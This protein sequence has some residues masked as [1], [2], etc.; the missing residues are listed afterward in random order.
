[1]KRLL[2]TSFILVFLAIWAKADALPTPVLYSPDD[3]AG[4]VPCPVHFDWGDVDGAEAYRIQVATSANG[5]NSKDGFQSQYV[6]KETRINDSFFLWSEMKSGRDYYWSVRAGNS[7]DGSYYAPYRR[8][9]GTFSN[10]CPP[11]L[12]SPANNAANVQEP[13]AFEWEDVESAEAY[14]I[15]VATS[16]SGWNSSNGFQ[17]QYLIFEERTNDSFFNWS[18]APAD[19][20]FYWCVRAGRN[21]VGSLYA[22]PFSF[23]TAAGNECVKPVIESVTPAAVDAGKIEEGALHIRGSNFKRC[24]P[25]YL[26]A[27]ISGLNG[28]TLASYSDTQIKLKYSSVQNTAGFQ[29][30]RVENSSDPQYQAERNNIFQIKEKDNEPGGD[31]FPE[32]CLKE[33]DVDET[34]CIY[35]GKEK[36]FFY[37]YRGYCTWYAYGRIQELSEGKYLPETLGD[38]FKDKFTNRSVLST[39]AKRWDEILGGVWYETSTFSL[40]MNMRKKGLLVLWDDDPTNSDNGKYG[41]VAFIE[42]VKEDKSEYRV[43]DFNYVDYLKYQDTKWRP[44][45]GNDKVNDVY[46]KFF[47]L[48]KKI[49][50]PELSKPGYCETGLSPL[51]VTFQWKF[52]KPAATVSKVEFT[53]KEASGPEGE[54]GEVLCANKDIGNT[55][56]YSSS[57]IAPLKENQWY[58]WWIYIYFNDGTETEKIVGYFKTGATA[59]TAPIIN[60]DRTQLNFGYTIGGSIPDSQNFGISNTGIGTL[61]WSVSVLNSW[62]KVSPDSGTGAGVVSVSINPEGLSAKSYRGAIRILDANAENSPRTVWVNLTVKDI[63]QDTAPFGSFDSPGEGAKVMGSVPVTGWALDDVEIASVK[64]YRDPVPGE[65]SRPVEISDAV[66]VEEARPDIY[67]AY[68]DYPENYKAGWGYMLLTNLLPNQGNGKFKLHAVAKDS[69]GHEVIL[70]TKTIICYNTNAVKPFGAIDTP[71]QGGTASGK[72]FVNWGWVL[73]PQPNSIPIDGST[74]NVYVDGIKLGNPIY[75]LYRSDI[76]ALFPNYANSNGAAGYFY[77]DTTGFK[78]GVHTLQWTATD[79]AGNTD[80]IGSRYFTIQNNGNNR[81]TSVNAIMQP[82]FVSDDNYRLLSRII[83]RSVHDLQS[84]GFRLGYKNGSR[85]DQIYPDDKGI[86]NIEI[87]ELER[88]EIHLGNIAEGYE[89]EKGIEKNRTYSGGHL[90]GDRLSDLPLGST[91]DTRRGIFYWQPGPGFIGEYRLLFVFMERNA[92]ITWKSIKITINSKFDK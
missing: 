7:T 50:D 81:Q 12:L 1:M 4:A 92:E 22:S 68:P 60:L 64:I 13:V 86:I 66:F 53:L 32:T 38:Q 65:G 87:S 89:F 62:I 90:I 91:L 73:T 25:G 58:K 56:K 31:K 40:P 83:D 67:S 70:G 41:H 3:N 34:D 79:S 76:A 45:V 37:E 46:P 52:N 49:D 51:D 16:A 44:F 63:T 35:A 43:S 57:Q 71:E 59:A 2:V 9:S 72:S 55:Q 30:V 77:L 80:G 23:T 11:V 10:L 20:E 48:T 33:K 18:E 61:S 17:E 54:G 29:V 21:L 84:V 75:N 27:F 36:N 69:S 24:E 42:E 26:K 15:Q 47:D 6:V 39:N 88:V 78:N 28:L 82:T 5:W 14:R 8:F 85:I 74:I 19:Q